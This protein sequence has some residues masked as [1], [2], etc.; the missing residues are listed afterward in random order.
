M[1]IPQDIFSHIVNMVEKAFR[2]SVNHGF[3]LLLGLR[4]RF[5]LRGKCSDIFNFIFQINSVDLFGQCRQQQQ[6]ESRIRYQQVFENMQNRKIL[7][8]S[9]IILAF[10]SSNAQKTMPF[11]EQL[12]LNFYSENILPLFPVAKKI[13][14]TKDV[15]DDSW[16]YDKGDCFKEIL[17]INKDSI[18]D[19]DYTRYYFGKNI[20]SIGKLTILKKYKKQFKFSNPK[21]R[22]KPMLRFTY[23]RIYN[24]T[25]YVNICEN[26][27]EK[28]FIYYL[29]MDIN[30]NVQKWCS[31]ELHFVTQH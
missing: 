7:I 13:S 2:T 27:E 20:D 18:L 28:V 23:P 26:K 30:G 8:F 6:S 15:I 25:V 4:L 10:Y 22:T 5:C 16:M 21:R 1:L 19:I 11:Y 9:F 3:R 29:K 24:N 12:A 17:N 14:L 31:K